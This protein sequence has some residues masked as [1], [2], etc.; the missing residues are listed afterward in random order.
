MTPTNKN[1]FTDKLYG[2]IDGWNSFQ[3]LNLFIPEL[4]ENLKLQVTW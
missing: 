3:Q 2:P 4:I 1:V